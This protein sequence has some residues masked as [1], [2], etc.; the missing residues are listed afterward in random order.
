[1]S[2]RPKK[3]KEDDNLECVRFVLD[4][5]DPDAEIGTYNKMDD[6]IKKFLKAYTLPSSAHPII[7]RALYRAAESALRW[8]NHKSV[9]HPRDEA[10]TRE[11]LSDLQALTE[12]NRRIQRY[13]PEQAFSVT[14]RDPD[15]ES[16]ALE[17][18]P[19]EQARRIERDIDAIQASSAR[20]ASL[21]ERFMRLTHIP[22]FKKDSSRTIVFT[23]YVIEDIA[24]HWR[25][26]VGRPLSVEDLPQM[27]ALIAAALLDFKYPLSRSQ[28]LSDDWLS[29]RIR[30]QIFQ[31]SSRLT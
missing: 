30:K 28:R 10:A 18:D 21:I 15:R 20:T 7:R 1:M 8:K 26:L 13:D 4:A 3:P 5:F 12:F 19:E 9:R 31:N 14:Y 2:K 27:T 16:D 22:E 6:Q 11:F 25:Q 29:D 23:H 17:L 24:L